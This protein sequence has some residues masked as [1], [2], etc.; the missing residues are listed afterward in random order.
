MAP[1]LQLSKLNRPSHAYGKR[2]RHSVVV[3]HGAP[4]LCPGGLR[5]SEVAGLCT[6]PVHE[7][8]RG[9]AQAILTRHTAEGLLQHCQTSR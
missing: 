8:V 4:E 3:R 1:L 7:C 2:R 9:V 6:G 5:T